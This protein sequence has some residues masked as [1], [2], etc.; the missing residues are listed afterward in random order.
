LKPSATTADFHPTFFIANPAGIFRRGFL[1]GLSRKNHRKAGQLIT[2]VNNQSSGLPSLGEQF[3][4]PRVETEYVTGVG[5]RMFA[6]FWVR[7]QTMNQIRHSAVS[8]STNSLVW[9]SPHRFGCRLVA[10]LA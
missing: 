9:Q 10:M 7:H 4:P 8:D 5:F 6:F 1:F 3:I 2:T